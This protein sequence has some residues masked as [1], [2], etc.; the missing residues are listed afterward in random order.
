MRIVDIFN[1]EKR[2]KLIIF[3][4]IYIYIIIY[5]IFHCYSD[6]SM[7]NIFLGDNYGFDRK[8]DK[9]IYRLLSKCGKGIFSNVGDLELKI[10]FDIKRKKEKLLTTD[11]EKWEKE[12]K[13]KLY[14]CSLIK[15][16][17]I[18]ELMKKK[19]TMF[20]K[21]YNHYEKNIMNGLDDKAF[22]KKMMLINDKDYK[23]LKR[24]KYG[25]RLCSLL[26]LFIL[27]LIIPIVDLSLGNFSTV[28]KL[29]NTL[30]SLLGYN[31]PPVDSAE[32]SGS[33]LSSTCQL[34]NLTGIKVFGVLVYCLPILILGIILI[35]GIFYYYKN[36]IKHK[37]LGFWKRLMN[38]KQ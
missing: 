22:F 17:L 21:S 28:G 9:R 24:K 3:I 13:E 6:M 32:S 27:V 26:L 8:L 31:E 25:L 12:K 29:L 34:K 15:D 19:S 37:K 7:F 18:K 1:M 20:H 10:P 2:F 23:K 11:N 35:Q 16:K 33:L 4:K 30:C 36:V 14:R 38:G 5:W